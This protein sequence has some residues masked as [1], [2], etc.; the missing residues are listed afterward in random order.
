M[1]NESKLQSDILGDLRSYGKYCECFKIEKTSDNG[2]PDIFFTTK[3]TGSVFI[4]TKRALGKAKKIQEYK[5]DKLKKCGSKAFICYTWFEWVCI[6]KLIGL[7]K[8]NVIIT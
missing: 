2:I 8:Q 7:D 4:E 3:F 5:I 1:R 6:K